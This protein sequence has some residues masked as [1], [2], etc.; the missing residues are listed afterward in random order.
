MSRTRSNRAPMP[1][2]RLPAPISV[3]PVVEPVEIEDPLNVALDDCETLV[4][5]IVANGGEAA[6][7]ARLARLLPA[8]TL[9]GG[10]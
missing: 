4:G 5:N 9:E 6:L 7:R 8:E 10:Q 1:R 3:Q 2:R